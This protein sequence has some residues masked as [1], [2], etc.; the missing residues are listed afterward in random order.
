MYSTKGRPRSLTDAQVKLILDWHASRK[1]L[2][3]LATELNVSK[4]TISNVIQ[5]AGKYKAPSPE[6]R[7]E[8]V[9][10]QRANRRRLR[11]AG[12]M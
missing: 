7:A 9:A 8:V 2:T 12:W 1:S 5:N 4:S 11:L 6:R 3:Q 10:Q